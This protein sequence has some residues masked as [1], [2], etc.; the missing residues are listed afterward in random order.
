MAFRCLTCNFKGRVA[1]QGACPACGSFSLEPVGRFKLEPETSKKRL[2]V[3]SLVM[4]GL[5]LYLAFVVYHLLT[6]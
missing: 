1:D 5:Y 6:R 3:K 4:A 2:T